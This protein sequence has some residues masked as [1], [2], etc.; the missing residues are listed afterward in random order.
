MKSVQAVGEAFRKNRP[1]WVKEGWTYNRLARAVYDELCEVDEES[2]A[3]FLETGGF[4]LGPRGGIR[5]RQEAAVA[6]AP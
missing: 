3:D 5:I 6:I 4:D 2:A 1:Q